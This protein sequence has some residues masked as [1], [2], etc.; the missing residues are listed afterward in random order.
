MFL[1]I[2][3]ITNMTTNINNKGNIKKTSFR[4]NNINAKI[5]ARTNSADIISP[6]LFE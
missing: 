4:I 1:D 6:Q 3:Y 2:P 5:I